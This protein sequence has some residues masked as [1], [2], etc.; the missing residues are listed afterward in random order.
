MVFFMATVASF[1]VFIAAFILV[2]IISDAG[3]VSDE[4]GTAL[5]AFL[6]V[7]LLVGVPWCIG[8]LVRAW[9]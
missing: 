3:I 6:L 7:G 9:T 2:T 1:G 4:V 5:G 8:L